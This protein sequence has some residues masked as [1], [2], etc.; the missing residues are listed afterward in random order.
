MDV[1]MWI[2]ICSLFPDNT[3]V[4]S[5]IN[6]ESNAYQYH[7]SDSSGIF[8]AANERIVP[9]DLKTAKKLLAEMQRRGA[10]PLIGLMGVPAELAAKYGLRPEELFDPCTNIKVGTAILSELS[11]GLS[12]GPMFRS[13][14]L[15]KYSSL[16]G[17]SNKD[18]LVN[19]VL[20]DIQSTNS[21]KHRAQ[22][23]SGDQADDYTILTEQNPDL[24]ESTEGWNNSSI[25]LEDRL[26]NGIQPSL[27]TEGQ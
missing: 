25:F 12:R 17:Y 11:E 26:N 23:I 8:A 19:S 24:I 20:A 21:K 15:R 22:A 3:L 13:A 16:L 2:M 9:D 7:M 18:Y 4:Q 27:Q 5:I 10:R 14:L 1:L 6:A